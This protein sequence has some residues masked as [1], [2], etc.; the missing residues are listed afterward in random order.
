MSKMYLDIHFRLLTVRHAS[1]ALFP[2]VDYFFSNW[3]LKCIKPMQ[4]CAGIWFILRS[5][6]RHQHNE[7]LQ[8]WSL[9]RLPKYSTCPS[10]PISPTTA[11]AS[12]RTSFKDSLQNVQGIKCF[13]Q[14]DRLTYTHP[15]TLVGLCP[16]QLSSR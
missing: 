5:G 12:T 10:P 6:G 14:T 11:A 4:R 1:F 2:A 15:N 13:F 16:E 9:C 7:Y 8:R 3:R